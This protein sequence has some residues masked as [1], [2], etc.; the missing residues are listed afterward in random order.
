MVLTPSGTGNKKCVPLQVLWASGGGCL[1]FRNL[2]REEERYSTQMDEQVRGKIISYL[3]EHPNA[4]ISKILSAVG[5]KSKSGF[6]RVFPDGIG[7]ACLAAGVTFDKGRMSRSAE[8]TEARRAMPLEVVENV[9]F[10]CEFDLTLR[11]SRIQAN[12]DALLKEF[13]DRTEASKNVPF[14]FA[15]R[16]RLTNLC[17]TV[18]GRL[19]KIR[20]EKGL[21]EVGEAYLKIWL[22]FSS[23]MGDIPGFEKSRSD[24]DML[25]SAFQTDSATASRKAGMVAELVDKYGLGRVD[26]FLRSAGLLAYSEDFGRAV[27]KKFVYTGELPPGLDEEEG[28]IVLTSIVNGERKET[29][30]RKLYNVSNL[31]ELR[32]KMLNQI[33]VSA[34]R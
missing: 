2:K 18:K 25:K 26:A 9:P 32:Q 11:K 15:Q 31:Q 4:S 28:D 13:Y 22:E 10:S 17:D 30:L 14:W 33:Y 6:Y 19:H 34:S 27:A 23:L 8:A 3:E 24:L 16:K 20:D 21:V 7:E 1:S 12:V 29:S 5:L